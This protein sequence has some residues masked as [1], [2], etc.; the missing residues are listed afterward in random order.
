MHIKT[1]KLQWNG[2]NRVILVFSLNSQYF[3]GGEFSLVVAGTVDIF[4]S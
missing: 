1:I 2:S 4:F 3:E